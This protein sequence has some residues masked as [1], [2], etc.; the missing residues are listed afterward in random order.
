MTFKTITNFNSIIYIW[1]IIKKSINFRSTARQSL[2][3]VAISVS[4]F[5]ISHYG[6]DR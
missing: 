6:D 1:N 5:V 3:E 4:E 2:D